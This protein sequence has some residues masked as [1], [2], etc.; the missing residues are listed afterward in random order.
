MLDK[1]IIKPNRKLIEKTRQYIETKLK[2]QKDNYTKI[3]VLCLSHQKKN[4]V[5]GMKKVGMQH[6]SERFMEMLD[7]DVFKYCYFYQ[8]NTMREKISTDDIPILLDYIDVVVSFGSFDPSPIDYRTLREFII[9]MYKIGKPMINICLS[10]QEMIKAFGGE[11]AVE[12]GSQGGIT[13]YQLTEQGK[14]DPAFKR[15]SE[16]FLGEIPANAIHRDSVLEIP[17]D[18]FDL[19]GYDSYC[20]QAVKLGDLIWGF[21]H[22]PDIYEVKSI[23]KLQEKE[24]LLDERT[25]KNNLH[26]LEKSGE[27]LTFK[28]ILLSN[29]MIINDIFKEIMRY[30]KLG[31]LMHRRNGT[32]RRSFFKNK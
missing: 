15:A 14:K 19:L 22:H 27:K 28:N 2:D 23:L 24:Q 6:D 12:Q 32:V 26:K 8:H 3:R 18:Y 10:F 17:E 30:K 1:K 29:K 4:V 20:I 16:Y 5:D 11:T 31:L 13:F 21:Q 25:V 7:S 9:K